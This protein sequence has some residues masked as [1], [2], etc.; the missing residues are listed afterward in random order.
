MEVVDGT[1][2]HL[3]GILTVSQCRRDARHY[4]RRNAPDVTRSST[5]NM[6]AENGDDPPGMLQSPAKHRHY[7]WRLKVERV[8]P[9]LNF[10]GWVVRE[11]RNRFGDLQIDHFD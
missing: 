11:N 4:R 1:H 10:K 6:T 2:L 7:L 8:W 5:V 3:S 9:Y